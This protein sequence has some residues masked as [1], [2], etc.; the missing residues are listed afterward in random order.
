M[1]P[2]LRQRISLQITRFVKCNN[3]R[4]DKNDLQTVPGLLNQTFCENSLN[5]KDEEDESAGYLRIRRKRLERFSHVAMARKEMAES[6]GKRR[7]LH[8]SISELSKSIL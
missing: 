2:G 6:R 3:N 1:D 5:L 4:H 8:E 7:R